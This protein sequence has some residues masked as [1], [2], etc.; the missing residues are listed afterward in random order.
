MDILVCYDVNTEDREGRRRLRHVAKHCTVFGQR[1][2]KSIFECR[3][4]DAQLE[5]LKYHLKKAIDVD[6]DSIRI[7]KLRQPREDHVECIGKDVYT[8]FDDPMVF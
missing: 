3:V 1:V 4:D 2:Q 7:Y 5:R 6:T 8:D